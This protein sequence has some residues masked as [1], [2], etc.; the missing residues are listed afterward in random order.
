MT[1][2]MVMVVVQ[3][4]A[5]VVIFRGGHSPST[6]GPQGTTVLCP[7]SFLLMTGK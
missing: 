5:T 2:L 4:M 7:L 1:V 6:T 3:T